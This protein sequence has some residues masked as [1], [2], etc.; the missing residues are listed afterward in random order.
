MSDETTPQ[1]RWSVRKWVD[2]GQTATIIA[3]ALSLFSFYRSYV[4]M[5]DQR[6]GS[7]SL[8]PRG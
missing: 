8:A 7:R 4:K 3:L 1:R 6:L 5:V 2:I